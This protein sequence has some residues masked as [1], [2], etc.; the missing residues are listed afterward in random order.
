MDSSS[1]RHV[2]LNLSQTTRGIWLACPNMESKHL[3]LVMDTEG[4]DGSEREDDTTFEKQSA[5]FALSVANVVIV[6]IWSHDIGRE[7]GAS[8]PLLAAVFQ[9]EKIKFCDKQPKITLMLVIRDKGPIWDSIPTPKGKNISLD[10]VFEVKF[11]FLP[12]YEYQ[13]ED[14]R[15]EVVIFKKRLDRYCTKAGNQ[16][17]PTSGFSTYAQKIWIDIK[18]NKNLNLPAHKVMVATIRCEEIKTEKY[19]AFEMN[20]DWLELRKATQLGNF[21]AIRRLWKTVNSVLNNCVSELVLLFYEL[22]L[23]LFV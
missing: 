1:G 5:L 8:K 2:F 9:Q 18:G 19:D 10:E 6:N 16:K 13:N 11:V 20:K 17:L 4:T 3:M 23:A 12:H 7:Q 21:G 22:P 15:K 14:F